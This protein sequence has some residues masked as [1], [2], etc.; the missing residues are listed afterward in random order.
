MT[1]AA[2]IKGLAIGWECNGVDCDLDDHSCEACIE[3]QLSDYE[4]CIKAETIDKCI[5]TLYEVT[6]NT[7]DQKLDMIFVNAL[8]QLKVE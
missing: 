8:R 2:I 5:E 1:R 4:M 6:P 7:V 3:K